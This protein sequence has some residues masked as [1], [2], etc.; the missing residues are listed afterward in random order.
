VEL[1]DFAGPRNNQL[2]IERK[3]DVGRKG[4]SKWKKLPREG[5]TERKKKKRVAKKLRS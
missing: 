2:N 1:G 4:F 3:G 5:V